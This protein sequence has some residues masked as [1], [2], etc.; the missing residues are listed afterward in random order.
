MSYYLT[1]VVWVLQE[2][3]Q[4]VQPEIILEVGPGHG[5][6]ALVYAGL[7][8]LWAANSSYAGKVFAI[9]E[10]TPSDTRDIDPRP[11]RHLFMIISYC[12]V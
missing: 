2:L 4:S 8:H 7:M 5:G 12:L 10:L 3:L 1:C 9:G 11:S 6:A